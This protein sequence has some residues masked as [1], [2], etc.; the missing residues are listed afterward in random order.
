MTSKGTFINV[1]IMLA[2]DGGH[3][4][5]TPLIEYMVDEFERPI[6]GT[7]L[8]IKGKPFRVISQTPSGLPD[9]AEVTYLVE[10]DNTNAPYKRNLREPSG[11]R[12]SA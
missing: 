12:A 9:N 6:V 2:G 5:D 7:I 1:K 8:S 11:Y 4:K 10:L 3:I